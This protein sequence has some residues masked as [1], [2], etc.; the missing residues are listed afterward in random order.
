MLCYSSRCSRRRSLEISAPEEPALSLLQFTPHFPGFADT[1][2]HHSSTCVEVLR[3]S[4]ALVSCWRACHLI[5]LV[6]SNLFDFVGF[7]SVFHVC[8]TYRCTLQ[9]ILYSTQ[10]INLTHDTAEL[11]VVVTDL[12]VEGL[13]L[14]KKHQLSF[15]VVLVL[16]VNQGFWLLLG[17]NTMCLGVGIEVFK[18]VAVSK[19]LLDVCDAGLSLLPLIMLL[20][21]VEILFGES[22]PSQWSVLLLAA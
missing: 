22:K 15:H 17:L 11:L 9:G 4:H 20:T 21:D 5:S 7:E 6:P 2:K 1:V 10:L 13:W 19:L 18:T 8:F 12:F 14:F 16:I 3:V